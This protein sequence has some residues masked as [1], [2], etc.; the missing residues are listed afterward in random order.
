MGNDTYGGTGGTG[1][2]TPTPWESNK[3]YYNGEQVTFDGWVYLCTVA[4]T[5]S[6][7]FAADIFAQY[8]DTVNGSNTW[9]SNR[10]YSVSNSV[11]Y[12]GVTYYRKTAGASSI[13]PN[14]DRDNWTTTA[15]SAG[16]SYPPY[17]ARQAYAIYSKVTYNNVT[18]AAINR[19]DAGASTDP[20][21]ETAWARLWVSN[22][23]VPFS[24]IC[25]DV[26]K[27]VYVLN[28]SGSNVQFQ[29]PL[30]NSVDYQIYTS[31]VA[32]ISYNLNDPVLYQGATYYAQ[33]NMVSTDV[34][35]PSN[36]QWSTT[37]YT[38]PPLCLTA[39][40]RVLT[41]NGYVPV[42]TLKKGEYVTVADGR[43]VL[44][45]Y[46]H[47]SHHDNVNRVSAPYIVPAHALGENIPCNTVRLSPEHAVHIGNDCWLTPRHMEKRSDKVVQY[48]MGE[49]VN[50][51]TFKTP[52]YFKDNLVI[53]DG[54]A[55]ESYG[56]RYLIFDKGINAYRRIPKV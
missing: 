54:V 28:N 4:H 3:S 12:A 44:I 13:P 23:N 34:P 14:S 24:Y 11:I 15:P 8:W 16:V 38:P 37:I 27:Y 53:E 32:D 19:I 48:G 18:Y 21:G 45:T 31:W 40:T 1:T 55:V 47:K 39:G 29:T 46:V 36:A 25:Y 2:I 22:N 17:V 26:N 50:Y 6:S 56:P 10:T 35:P 9:E 52:D 49:S 7:D 30:D 42:E 5:S 51:Y 43:D 20:S 33:L 41:P